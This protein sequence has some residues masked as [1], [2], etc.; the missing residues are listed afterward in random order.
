MFDKEES[1]IVEENYNYRVLHIFS[2]YGGGI[3]S[4]ILNLIE[5][6]SKDFK[7]DLMAFSYQNGDVFLE[8]VR[9]MGA[10]IYQMPRPRIDGYKKFINYLNDV[11]SKNKYDVVHCHITGWHAKPFMNVAKKHGIKNFILHAH[12]T[13][14][15]SRIDRL[16]PVQLYDKYLNYKNSVAYMTCSDLAA[17][18]I[19]GEKYLSKR[20]AYLIPNGMDETFFLDALSDEQKSAYH[21]E[22]YIP[23]GAFVIGHVGRF[24]T[25][26]NHFFILDIAN[27]L[28]RKNVNFV[29]LLVGSGELFDSVKKKAE[30][31]GLENN[32]RF[33]GRRTDIASLMQ[34]F[35]CMIL[36]S[37]YEGL[38]TVAIECQASGTHMIL[39]DAITKQCDMKLGLLDFM[40][41][42]D[43]SLWADAIE[44]TCKL[45]HINNLECLAQIKKQ[46]FT[47]TV[48]G[49][50]Y[51]DIL[52]NIIAE[53]A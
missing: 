47:A 9:R 31:C 18:Y 38:P 25:Q 24:S 35:D 45:E 42:E 27:E 48:A 44:N 2:S 8:R 39:S 11:F 6:K 15:D 40:P 3:S 37:F 26:K 36:P 51:C 53:N 19:Y 33:V 49:K 7:F 43:A 29:L 17:S 4:L 23:E 22:F 41:I 14:Y 20:K 12:T 13:K 5:N 1:R 46:G 30:A 34:Y 10:D 16:P 52:R 21:K 28:K 32:I 50:Q